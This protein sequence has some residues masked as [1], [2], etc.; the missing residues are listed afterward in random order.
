MNPQ[1]NQYGKGDNIAGD[2]VA[3]NKIATQINH[4]ARQNSIVSTQAT[5]LFISYAVKDGS[6]AAQRLRAEL[7][8]AGFNVWRDVESM[9]GG[10]EWKK[11][12]RKAIKEVDAIVLLLSPAAVESR[13]VEWEWETAETLETPILPVVVVPCE[14]PHELDHLH[15]RD[16]SNADTYASNLASIFGDLR[17]IRDSS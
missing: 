3:G 11:Q 5:N 2:K 4:S 8:S 10:K 15:R 17:K 14:V 7:T 1:I 13:N 16:L 9:Q 6:T 12:L